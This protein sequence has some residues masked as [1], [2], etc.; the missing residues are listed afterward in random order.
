MTPEITV[1]EL[2][3]VELPE[4]HPRAGEGSCLIRAFVVR[5]GDGSVLFDTGVGADSDIIKD[6]YRPDSVPLLTA[7]N[8]AG[9]DERDVT[10]IVNS[11]LHFDHCGQNNALPTVPVWVQAAELAATEVPGYTVPAW[12]RLEP[13]RRRVID[14]DE[15]I[16]PGLTILATPGHTP[17]HQS[18][19]VTG[20][21][22]RRELIVGQACFC[23]AD[24]RA[25]R[26]DPGELHDESFA[27]AY[28]ESLKRLSGLGVTAAHFSHDAEVLASRT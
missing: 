21:G 23:C 4:S 9:I 11:H 3:T 22:G 8:D 24:F 2:G 20:S 10:A 15:E 5:H 14:G 17:G 7:L 1:L 19:L 18:L 12:A 13:G 6:L 25:D 28:A 26:V 27:A 16:A